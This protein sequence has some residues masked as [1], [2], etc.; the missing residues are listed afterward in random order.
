MINLIFK[1]QILEN[2]EKCRIIDNMRTEIEKK[3]LEGV[4]FSNEA[5]LALSVFPKSEI[6]T[7]FALKN[8][9]I[10]SCVEK[11]QAANLAF[12]TAGYTIPSFYESKK[13]EEKEWICY[14]ISPY[15]LEKIGWT[16]AADI[17]DFVIEVFTKLNCMPDEIINL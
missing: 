3:V 17:P 10:I 14:C 16:D 15:E 4:E 9:E 8:G 12:S 6:E 11:T 5:T 1:K 13:E 2:L 7:F